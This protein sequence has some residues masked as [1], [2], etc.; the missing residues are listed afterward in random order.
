MHSALTTVLAVGLCL[1]VVPGS[2]PA[3]SGLPVNRVL[4]LDGIG[5]YVE[6]PVGI[7]DSLSAATVEAW[8]RWDDFGYF[9]QWFHYGDSFG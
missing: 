5:D 6:L 3:Q 4:Q 8:V 7:Y 2:S 1:L 9:S